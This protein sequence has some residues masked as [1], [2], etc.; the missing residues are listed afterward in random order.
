[1]RELAPACPPNDARV[2]H[3]DRQALGGG[4]HRRGEP[5]G[6][7]P[8]DRDV[9]R[10]VGMI[11][12]RHAEDPSQVGLGRILEDRSVG[13]DDE[14][15]GRVTC[16]VVL[17]QGRGLVIA[18]GI[19]H[20]MGSGIASQEALETDQVGMD[21]RADQDGTPPPVSIKPA[22]RRR[23]ARMIRSPIS[24]SAINTVRR[25]SAGTRSTSLSQVARASTRR[26]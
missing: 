16:R 10:A 18:G 24:A 19:D 15:Q 7:R 1:M 13:A 6:P 2:E 12:A 14:R 20:P 4:V 22:R 26:G 11:D 8:D 9:V 3:D 25:R 17:E 5:R 23:S 21:G